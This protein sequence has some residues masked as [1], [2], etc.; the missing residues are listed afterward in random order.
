MGKGSQESIHR[1]KNCF[2]THNN[3]FNLI[4]DKRNTQENSNEIAFL[5]KKLAKIKRLNHIP[6]SRGRRKA[7]IADGSVNL[8]NVYG[9]QFNNIYQRYTDTYSL[10]WK[11]FYVILHSCKLK[12]SHSGC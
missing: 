12:D 11:F 7:Y 6:L 1:K 5:A 2:Y 8:Y 9:V 10:T 3:M 4:Y